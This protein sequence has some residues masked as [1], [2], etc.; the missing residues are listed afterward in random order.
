MQRQKKIAGRK[1][2][3]ETSSVCTSLHTAT[4]Q[5]QQHAIVIY[6]LHA[7]SLKTKDHAA[8]FRMT[9]NQHHVLELAQNENARAQNLYSVPPKETEREIFMRR[10]TV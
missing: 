5:D 1:G 6:A 9:I 8:R 2:G 10:E 4:T 3:M 7:C